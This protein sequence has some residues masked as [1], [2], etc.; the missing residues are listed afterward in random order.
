M[1]SADYTGVPVQKSDLVVNIIATHQSTE[2]RVYKKRW[3]ILGIFVIYSMSNSMQWIQY[4]IIA[5]VIEKYYSVPST[6]VDWTS[7]MYMVM[8]IPFIF[9]GS[10]LLDKLV[11]AFYFF[12]L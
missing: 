8:Y 1:L 2:C 4:S 7:M 12:I 9:P 6:H 5:N 11:S 3:L 10:W